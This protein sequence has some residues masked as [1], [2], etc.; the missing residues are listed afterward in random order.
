MNNIY[1]T[2]QRWFKKEKDKREE[3]EYNTSFEILPSHI[4]TI[5]DNI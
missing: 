2:V 5:D 3:K 4:D 1:T